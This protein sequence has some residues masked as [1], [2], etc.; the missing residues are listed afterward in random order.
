M[1]RPAIRAQR[2]LRWTDGT[3]EG[4]LAHRLRLRRFHFFRS[5]LACVPRP[6]RILDVGGSVDFWRGMRFPSEPGIEVVVL[7]LDVQPAELPPYRLVRGDGRDMRQFGEQELDVVF[8]N[9]V[10]EHAGSVA[11]QR[12]MANEVQR[13]GR[14]YFVQT[15]NYYFPIEPHF[16][17]PGFQFLPTAVRVLLLQ[18]FDLGDHARVPNA[19]RA[20]ADVTSIQLLS[21]SELQAL[22]PGARIWR[23][24]IF[25]LSKSLVA[26]GGWESPCLGTAT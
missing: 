17:F 16:L 12:R 23:E 26:Y 20:R 24:R 4:T 11:D 13:V 9:S 19:E 2:A 6:L 18:H 1:P 21:S 10:I 3:V 15:P 7:N 14:R 25:G 5:L 8:S 22:F